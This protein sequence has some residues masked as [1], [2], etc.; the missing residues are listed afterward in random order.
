[1][2]DVVVEID[3][4]E[5]ESA[6]FAFQRGRRSQQVVI[7]DRFDT[8]DIGDFLRQVLDE[9]EVLGTFGGHG[10]RVTRQI[11][12]N[13]ELGRVD[14]KLGLEEF[15]YFGRIRVRIVV[16]TTLEISKGLKT[17]ERRKC[18]ETHETEEDE[19]GIV[20]DEVGE[21]PHEVLLSA[22]P[23]HH[24]RPNQEVAEWSAFCG[25]GVWFGNPLCR[26]T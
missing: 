7:H 15:G 8:L 2:F 23:I 17:P 19:L 6:V 11:D 24:T 18:N 9:G 4:N 1:M 14:V 3:Q 16:S 10:V 21:A 22:K 13:D 20:R 12:E 5:N 26:R 25:T